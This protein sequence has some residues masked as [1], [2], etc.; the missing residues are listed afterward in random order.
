MLQ[1]HPSN[2]FRP[3]NWRWE[4]ARL[5]RENN[6]RATS[7]AFKQDSYTNKAYMFQVDLAKCTDD[8]ARWELMTRKPGLYAAYMLYKRGV[9]EDRHPLRY[10]LEARLLSAQDQESIAKALGITL[11]TVALYEKIFFNVL[12]KLENTDYVLNC[13]IGPSIYAGLN[14]RDYDLLWKLFGY[15][16]GPL[17]LE[18]F[19][20][21]TT[22]KFRPDTM[23]AVDAVLSEDTRSSLQRKVAIVARTYTVNPFSQSELLN[24]YA[25]FLEFEKQTGSDKSQDV[26]L[27]NI[28]VMM[29]ALP[30]TTGSQE[31]DNVKIVPTLIGDNKSIELRTDEILNAVVT[32]SQVTTEDLTGYKFPEDSDATK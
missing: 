13:V 27:Q 9:E 17:V 19:I 25:R 24:I 6:Y 21:T 7:H 4:H 15:L 31:L 32:E 1:Y 5:L 26:I 10:A 3:V 20:T 22:R 14:D 16:Y 29:K 2:P 12:D 11:E 28:Q 23:E 18:T 8:L 30:F